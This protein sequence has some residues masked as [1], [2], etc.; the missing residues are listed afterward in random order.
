MREDD[1]L[2]EL[3]GGELMKLI[4]VNFVKNRKSLLIIRLTL[5]AQFSPSSLSPSLSSL[6]CVFRHDVEII[7]VVMPCFRNIVKFSRYLVCKSHLFPFFVT[8]LFLLSMHTSWKHRLAFGEL[9]NSESM[10][11]CFMS[12]FFL[13]HR[14][15]NGAM[16]CVGVYIGRST[17]TSV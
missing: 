7:V 4:S 13:V 9:P 11:M 16:S 6:T 1:L 3:R 10:S 15:T 17:S 14:S 12:K 2:E 8:G 5:A